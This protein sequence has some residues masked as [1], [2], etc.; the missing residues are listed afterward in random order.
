[1]LSGG[2]PN[3]ETSAQL[4]VGWSPSRLLRPTLTFAQRKPLGAAGG[5]VLI[6]LILIAILAPVVSPHDPYEIHQD[7]VL[8]APQRVFPL[9]TDELGRDVLSRIF[10]G[11]RISMYVGVSSVL[12]GVTLGF[13]LGTV[14]GYVGGKF[15]LLF[16]RLIDA[17]LSFPTIILALAIIAVLGAGINNVIL[18]L[19]IVLV[20]S[21]SR[22]IRSQVLSIKEMDYVLAATAVGCSSTRIIS[23]HL[24]PN[25][26]ATYIILATLTLGL[27]I[28][29]EASLSF[30]GLG[31]PPDVPSWGGMLTVAARQY[32]RNAPWLA[33]SPG[34]AVALAVFA[35]NLFGDSLRDVLDPKLRGR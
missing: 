13:I 21:T 17:L 24:M 26:F 35:V 12:I 14:S 11:A 27:A 3:T 1:M 6:V 8:G 28:T 2:K 5:V 25:C 23:R 29:T 15:D 22:T 9:G 32:V 7:T 18:A 19:V 4:H 33:I 16:Q 20:P 31:V 30:L 10:F 34:I